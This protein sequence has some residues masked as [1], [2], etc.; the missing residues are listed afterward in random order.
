MIGSSLSDSFQNV[1]NRNMKKIFC[2]SIFCFFFSEVFAQQPAVAPPVIIEQHYRGTLGSKTHIYMKLVQKDDSIAG[3]YLN[4]VN[5]EPVRLMGVLKKRQLVLDELSYDSVGAATRTA[6]FTVGLEIK[7][8]PE[9]ISGLRVTTDGK[10]TDPFFVAKSGYMLPLWQ[11]LQKVHIPFTPPDSFAR[12]SGITFAIKGMA[13]QDVERKINRII[14]QKAYR[15]FTGGMMPIKEG[16]MDS[17]GW[18]DEHHYSIEFMT[19]RLISITTYFSKMD[20]SQKTVDGVGGLTLDL[21]AGEELKLR[22]VIKPA[23]L[24]QFFTLCKRS[25][26]KCMNKTEK[27]LEQSKFAGCVTDIGA[28][29]DFTVTPLGIQ[30]SFTSCLPKSRQS[31][32]VPLLQWSEIRNMIIADGVLREFVK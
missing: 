21:I 7:A 12:T 17:V 5:G 3:S 14:R 20:E 31:C 15:T 10:K 8:L 6:T 11:F 29:T 2:V 19:D 22:D 24:N 9:T 28:Y 23:S 13:D 4:E 26:A 30:L 1:V 16:A 18:Y 27:E 25:M 32:G